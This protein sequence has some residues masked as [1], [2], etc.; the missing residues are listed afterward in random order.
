MAQQVRGLAAKPDNLS[1]IPRTQV[2]SLTLLIP[3]QSHLHRHAHTINNTFER[4]KDIF[5]SPPVLLPPPS[6]QITA[7][8]IS[9]LTSVSHSQWIHGQVE[10]S[11]TS[12]VN[13]KQ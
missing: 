3:C 9:S 2:F 7:L 12:E 10:K 1:L 5:I 4:K 11:E 13:M 8:K 6:F